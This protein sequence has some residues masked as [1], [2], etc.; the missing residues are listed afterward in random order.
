MFKDVKA[1]GPVTQSK[2]LQNLGLQAR[3]EMLL[4]HAKTAESRMNVIKSVQRLIDPAM[5]GRIY[6]VLAFSKTHTP[7]EDTKPVAF[8]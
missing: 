3:T 1:F 4:K 8:E 6:K 5:L 7:S 2:F